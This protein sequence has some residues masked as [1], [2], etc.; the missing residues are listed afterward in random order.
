MQLSLE[1]DSTESLSNQPQ[2]TPKKSSREVTQHKRIDA[3]VRF[4]KEFD[5]ALEI[6][7]G[8][9][10]K[11]D[12]LGRHAMALLLRLHG[13]LSSMGKGC[14]PTLPIEAKLLEELVRMT[15]SHSDNERIHKNDFLQILLG[16][17]GLRV[18]RADYATLYTKGKIFVQYFDSDVLELSPGDV[19]NLRKKFKPLNINRTQSH[20]TIDTSLTSEK[21]IDGSLARHFAKQ[22][23]Q[24]N[25]SKEIYSSY[26]KSL[27]FYFQSEL[28]SIQNCRMISRLGDS[29]DA[30]LHASLEFRPAS[31]TPLPFRP[32]K[33]IQSVHSVGSDSR[34]S[35][36][37]KKT[38]EGDVFQIMKNFKRPTPSSPLI[39]STEFHANSPSSTVKKHSL[40]L[41]DKKQILNSSIQSDKQHKQPKLA[42]SFYLSEEEDCPGQGIYRGIYS[43]DLDNER[44]DIYSKNH[45]RSCEKDQPPG[46]IYDVPNTPQVTRKQPDILEKILAKS[47]TMSSQNKNRD[48]EV[49]HRSLN[50]DDHQDNHLDF[51]QLKCVIDRV[52]NEFSKSRF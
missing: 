52:A 29:F 22:L 11:A 40:N 28:K 46:S 10:Q 45:P 1:V 24:E 21:K 5:L 13:F 16:I 35:L 44:T 48:K 36:T 12:F 4:V 20:F 43:K 8:K 42:S 49:Q 41:G 7:T 31:L 30:D 37:K 18:K 50:P 26:L 19:E 25:I 2:P 3:I 9:I 14:E 33:S 23:C 34:G 51:E 6:V 47:I 27:L 32:D 38:E 15:T 17:Q 39:Q